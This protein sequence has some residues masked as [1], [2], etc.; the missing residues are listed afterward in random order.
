MHAVPCIYGAPSPKATVHAACDMLHAR[1]RQPPVL[2]QLGVCGV[3]RRATPRDS[4]P[5]TGE[6]CARHD[7]EQRLRERER[8]RDE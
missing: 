4:Q 5:V 6:G 3:A 1:R 2:D 7:D 8:E